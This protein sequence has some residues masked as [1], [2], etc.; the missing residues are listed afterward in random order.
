MRRPSP[1]TAGQRQVLGAPRCESTAQIE[2]FGKSLCR[3]L[4]CRRGAQRSGIVVYDDGLFLV[5]LQ[6]LG[7]LQN[8]VTIHL[9]RT[10]HVT[11]RILLLRTQ[12][13]QQRTLVHQPDR[14]LR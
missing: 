3:E 7:S 6:S 11:G 1:S 8:L 14:V 4:A 2:G 5:L 9:A 13:D 12:V 10:A